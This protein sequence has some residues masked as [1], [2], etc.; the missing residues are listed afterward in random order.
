M[1]YSVI[2]PVY[3]RPAEV[4]EL[5]SSLTRVSYKSFEILIIEDG[6]TETCD[7]VVQDFAHLLNLKYFKKENSGQGF[8]RNFG[9]ER[10]SGDYLV[11]FDSDCIIP[12]GYFKA[13]DRMIQ[14]DGSLDCWGGPDRAH[15]SFTPIQKAIN[16][17][18]TSFLTTGGTRGNRLHVGTYLPRSFN[19]GISREVF[20][21]TGGYKITRMGEDLE[22]SIRIQKNG[23]QT[24]FVEDAFVYHKRRTN[25]SQFFRQLFF[26]G[27]ARINIW[28]FH[29]GQLKVI[30]MFPSLFLLGLLYGLAGLLLGLPL[31]SAIILLYG[32]FLVVLGIDAFRSENSGRVAFLSSIAGLIQLSAYGAGFLKELLKG[33]RVRQ[34]VR[35]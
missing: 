1:R 22:F 21:A 5:L 32:V 19:M 29:P 33:S 25:F 31:A 34:E 23:Y 12:P 6:S 26:F 35:E 17:S 16:H 18:M 9:F 3:N 10:A 15:P 11:V 8:T 7:E 4:K 14:K 24:H 27:R 30:H 13:V 2:I 20:H 28:R